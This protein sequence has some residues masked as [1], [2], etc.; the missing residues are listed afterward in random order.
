MEGACFVSCPTLLETP[1]P[2]GDHQS[3]HKLGVE[4]GVTGQ[5]LIL[6]G[7]QIKAAPPQPLPVTRAGSPFSY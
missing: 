5:W 4:D 6:L 2:P 3:P 1:Q 7:G